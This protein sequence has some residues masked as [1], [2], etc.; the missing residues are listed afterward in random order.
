MRAIPEQPASD[1]EPQARPLQVLNRHSAWIAA[2]LVLA[3][4]LH[5]GSR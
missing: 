4:A 2:A 5:A 3:I 1:H